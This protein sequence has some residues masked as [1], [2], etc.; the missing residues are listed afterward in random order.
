M[1]DMELLELVA[2]AVTPLLDC[3]SPPGA[4]DDDDDDVD[5]DE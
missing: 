3:R 1:L 4:D 5:D 2:A